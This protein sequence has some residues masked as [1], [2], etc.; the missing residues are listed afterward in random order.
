TLSG[1][2]TASGGP[3]RGDRIPEELVQLVDEPPGAPDRAGLPDLLQ[4]RADVGKA[5]GSDG[6][7]APFQRVG[8]LAKRRRVVLLHRGHEEGAQPSGVRCELFHEIREEPRT[9]GRRE[10]LQL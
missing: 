9:P 4:L 3:E 5:D 7:T 2:A 1:A 6:S 8:G 10:S